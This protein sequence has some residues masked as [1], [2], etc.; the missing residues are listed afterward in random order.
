MQTLRD[1]IKTDGWRPRGRGKKS[2]RQ[3]LSRK[4]TGTVRRYATDEEHMKRRVVRKCFGVLTIL[5]ES[6]C[7]GEPNNLGPHIN[8]PPIIMTSIRPIT[9][10]II[11]I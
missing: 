11:I 3:I 1:T 8:L 2:D 7:V 5:R 10:I 6:F 9:P 4:T